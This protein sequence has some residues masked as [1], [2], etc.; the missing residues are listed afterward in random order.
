[1]RSC[2]FFILIL[3]FTCSSCISKPPQKPVDY[4]APYKDKNV[5]DGEKAADIWNM[6]VV[7]LFQ[8]AQGA[9]QNNL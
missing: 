4:Q 3:L 7:L 8:T 2:S 1:M 5:T 9:T 6:F